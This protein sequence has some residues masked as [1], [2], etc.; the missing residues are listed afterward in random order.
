M[1]V[2]EF[3]MI[4]CDNRSKYKFMNSCNCCYGCDVDK[5]VSSCVL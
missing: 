2:F 5:S 1:L 4:V 3:E